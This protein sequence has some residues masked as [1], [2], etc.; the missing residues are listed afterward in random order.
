MTSMKVET[1][2]GVR[3][4]VP[5]GVMRDA[6]GS[7]HQV[8]WRFSRYPGRQ[9]SS[10]GVESERGAARGYK[11]NHAYTAADIRA[12]FEAGCRETREN[13]GCPSDFLI[14]RASDAYV[15]LVHPLTTG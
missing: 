3:Y 12:A 9:P 1:P 15:K 6:F 5:S 13:G 10:D 2:L 14:E 11:Q 7:P 4:L 8:R